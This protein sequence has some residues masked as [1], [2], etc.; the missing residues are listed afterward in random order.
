MLFFYQKI[1][2]V[3][4]DA[5]E[6]HSEK[7]SLNNILKVNEQKLMQG[8]DDFHFAWVWLQIVIVGNHPNNL[9]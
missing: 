9:R 8:I 4:I 5:C 7:K 3:C 6:K 1:L 2:L